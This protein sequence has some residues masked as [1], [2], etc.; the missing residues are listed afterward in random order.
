MKRRAFYIIVLSAFIG[1]GIFFSRSFARVEQYQGRESGPRNMLMGDKMEE[2]KK[3]CQM[4]IGYFDQ[5]IAQIRDA[6]TTD[7]YQKMMAELDSA[8]KFARETKEHLTACNNL[9]QSMGG[10]SALPVGL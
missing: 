8:E 7:D 1:M 5:L 10:G 2:S 4:S 3:H 6:K 9:V